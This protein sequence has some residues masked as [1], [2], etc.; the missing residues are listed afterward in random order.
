MSNKDEEQVM[1]V[2]AEVFFRNGTF[3]GLNQNLLRF[4]PNLHAPE[5]LTFRTR[6]DCEQDPNFKQIIPYVVLF[7]RYEGRVQVFSYSRSPLQGE[8]R[9][10]GRRSIGIGGHVGTEDAR[11]NPDNP[12]TWANHG[13]LRELKEELD[14]VPQRQFVR[15]GVI[16]DDIDPVGAVHIGLLTVLE[17]NGDELSPEESMHDPKFIDLCD[18]VAEGTEEYENWS[19]IAI[20]YLAEE[21]IGCED[22]STKFEVDYSK[23]YEAWSEDDQ[24]LEDHVV[25]PVVISSLSLNSPPYAVVLTKHDGQIALAN[26]MAFAKEAGVKLPF[27]S[28]VSDDSPVVLEDLKENPDTGLIGSRVSDQAVIYFTEAALDDVSAK[29]NSQYSD[30]YPIPG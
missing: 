9:L 19:R 17:V 1:G 29:L 24:L 27:T 3:K 15:L 25:V 21:Y 6:G 16:Y 2:T 11:L 18:L 30:K 26:T 8:E 12:R 23:T 22:M 4:D 20:K 5:A 10:V 28:M 7:R 14:I 13:M